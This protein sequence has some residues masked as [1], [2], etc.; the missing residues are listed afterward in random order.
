MVNSTVNKKQIS[1]GAAGI[2]DKVTTNAVA[3]LNNKPQKLEIEVINSKEIR[4]IPFIIE[5][6]DIV[7]STDDAVTI[8]CKPNTREDVAKRNSKEL[9]EESR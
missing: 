9:S 4:N 1:E 2:N 8:K 7:S 5:Q 6:G 3:W